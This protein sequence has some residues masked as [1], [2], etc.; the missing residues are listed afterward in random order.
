M[1]LKKL[2]KNK[3]AFTLVELVVVI[4]ILGILAAVASVSTIAILNNAR[5]TTTETAA[6]AVKTILDNKAADGSLSSKTKAS[7][8]KSWIS[9]GV[10]D[11]TVEASGTVSGDKPTAADGKQAHIKVGAADTTTIG[12]T[13]MKIYVYSQYY[14]LTMTV[15]ASGNITIGDTNKY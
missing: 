8:L 6:S 2:C 7:D 11:V 3:L 1:R 9:E 10:K 12:S 13:G 14:Y 15:D 5:K 4:A